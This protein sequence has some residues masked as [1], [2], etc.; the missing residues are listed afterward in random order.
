MGRQGEEDEEDDE[1]VEGKEEEEE[2]EEEEK[3]EDEVNSFV[4][5]FGSVIVL[6]VRP[7]LVTLRA[8]LKHVEVLQGNITATGLTPTCWPVLK[9]TKMPLK[10]IYRPLLSFELKSL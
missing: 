10:N 1:E 9:P 6:S 4:P 2:E 5:W 8:V 7:L 3:E